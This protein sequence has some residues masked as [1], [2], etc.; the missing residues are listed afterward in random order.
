MTNPTICIIDDD[1]SY[2]YLFNREIRALHFVNKTLSFSDGEE[3][4]HFFKQ[5]HDRADEIPDVVFLDINMP[6]MDGWDFLQ[7]YTKLKSSLC[8]PVAI[9][10]I[11]SSIDEADKNRAHNIKEL[12]AYIVKPIATQELYEIL[13]SFDSK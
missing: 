4:I 2:R 9:Y 13:A 12:S 3:A 11:S 6:I 7:E 1:D 5:Y 10:M 8:K